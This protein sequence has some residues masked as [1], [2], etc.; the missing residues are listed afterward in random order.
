MG[1][2][3]LELADVLCPVDPSEGPDAADDAAVEGALGKIRVSNPL[4]FV[5]LPAEDI[6]VRVKERSLTDVGVVLELADV[7]PAIG[8]KVSSASVSDVVGKF[9]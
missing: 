5:L 3:V 7:L 1:E 6:V 8:P 4:T 2:I 9:P